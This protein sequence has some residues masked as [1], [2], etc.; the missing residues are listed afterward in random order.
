MLLT[1]LFSHL[2]FRL[3]LLIVLLCTAIPA[4]GGRSLAENDAWQH[5]GF[6]VCDLP[7]FVG[8]TPGRTPFIELP[9]LL[10]RSI[11]L[12]ENHMFYNIT[13]INFWASLPLAQL[14]GWAR[15]DQGVVSEMH[16]TSPLPFDY[17]LTHLNTPDCV[18]PGSDRPTVV[19][20][21]RSAVSI[22]AVL[23]VGEDDFSPNSRVSALW[24]R[25]STPNDCEKSGA[26]AWHGFAIMSDYAP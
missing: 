16:L 15:N 20:W 9:D 8:I 21:I 25:N 14:S 18:L 22:G 11:P 1:S 23:G 10:H 24:L 12:I 19:Y 4:L 5:F 2:M 6:T 26:Q 13:A 7:C 3:L 17:L